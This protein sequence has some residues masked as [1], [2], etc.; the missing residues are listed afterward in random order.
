VSHTVVTVSQRNE[1]VD[2]E[3]LQAHRR[4]RCV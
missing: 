2:R 4:R 3:P 1:I